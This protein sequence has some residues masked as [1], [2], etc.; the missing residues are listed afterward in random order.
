MIL[1][2]LIQWGNIQKLIK[3]LINF[4]DTI[5]HL[6]PIAIRTFVFGA[7]CTGDN[8]I[9]F[10]RVR[11]HLFMYT[12]SVDV[13]FAALIHLSTVVCFSGNRF[14]DIFN[15]TGDHAACD[16][17]SIDNSCLVVQ[18][19]ENRCSEYAHRDRFCA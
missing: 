19:D 1:A 3:A 13:N 8:F 15:D 11:Y 4:Q 2:V 9:L 12:F 16:P 10:Y 6:L 14:F 18:L 7:V 17:Y 5:F